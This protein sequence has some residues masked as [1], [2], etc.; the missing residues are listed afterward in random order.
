[1]VLSILRYRSPVLRV[2]LAAV[3]RRGDLLWIGRI[4]WRGSPAARW[5][6]FFLLSVSVLANLAAVRD[7]IASYLGALAR[8]ADQDAREELSASCRLAWVDLITRV[9]G[10]PSIR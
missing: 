10:T 2:S 4:R 9:E 5:P 3:R 1:M 7:E 8:V 6:G